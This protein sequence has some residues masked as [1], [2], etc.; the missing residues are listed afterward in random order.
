METALEKFQNAMNKTSLHWTKCIKVTA[1]GGKIVFIEC[2]GF[3]F[4]S[5]SRRDEK[6]GC[7]IKK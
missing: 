6:A 4:K 7:T 2:E 5:D 3:C 1:Q